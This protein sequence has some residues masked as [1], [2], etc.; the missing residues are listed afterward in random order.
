MINQE[1]WFKMKFY[2]RPTNNPDT[3]ISLYFFHIY[4][5]CI[6]HYVFFSNFKLEKTLLG[7]LSLAL[8]FLLNLSILIWSI[9]RT[10]KV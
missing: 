5:N 4:C 8:T 7:F 6:F 9:S 10:R 3:I 2:Y 1:I